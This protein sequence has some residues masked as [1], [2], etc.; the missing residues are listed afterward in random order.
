MVI[1]ARQPVGFFAGSSLEATAVSA[2]VS[3]P[4]TET[5]EASISHLTQNKQYVYFNSTI[6]YKHGCFIASGASSAKARPPSVWPVFVSKPLLTIPP[7]V[8]S[9]VNVMTR[10]FLCVVLCSA[11]DLS[12]TLTSTGYKCHLPFFNFR[13]V[14]FI[15]ATVEDNWA[16]DM[17]SDGRTVATLSFL[18]FDFQPWQETPT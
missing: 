15:G 18:S 10:R 2:V 7:T 11:T 12:D 13:L 16:E 9:T 5:R 4:L 17:A 6:P 3:G 8:V 1:V 14:Q